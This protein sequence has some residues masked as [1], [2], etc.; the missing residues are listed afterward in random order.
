MEV[1]ERPTEEYGDIGGLD[2]QIAE[3]TMHAFSVLLIV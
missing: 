3:V 1:D 2:K